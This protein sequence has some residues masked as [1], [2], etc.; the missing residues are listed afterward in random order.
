MEQQKARYL[1]EKLKKYFNAYD[2]HSAEIKIDNVGDDAF[3]ILNAVSFKSRVATLLLSLFL[4]AIC[5]GR[6]YLGD[7]KFA[8]VKIALN[9]GLNILS[10]FIPIAFMNI[11]ISLGLGVWYIAEIVLCYKRS[12][13]I[14]LQKF[15]TSIRDY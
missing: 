14:N 1:K 12:S 13:L 4:G 5:A 2:F 10:A 11:I 9:I 7:W 3:E 8:L 15:N 6:F